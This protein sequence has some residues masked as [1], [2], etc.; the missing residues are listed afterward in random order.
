M[1]QNRYDLEMIQGATFQLQLYITDANTNPIDLTTYSALMELRPCYGSNTITDQLSTA[2]SE[3]LIGS[4]AGIYQLTLPAVRTANLPVD[5]CRGG[6]P[7]KEMY[8]YDFNLTS[9]TGIV[10][11]IIYGNVSVYGQV[12]R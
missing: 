7:P 10:T 1:Q 12:S 5:F 3:I 4:N 6:F 11:K 9:N 8:V 2:N